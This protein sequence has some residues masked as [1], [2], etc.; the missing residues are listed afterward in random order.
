MT[1]LRYNIIVVTM[2]PD[3][4][5]LSGA[6]WPVLPA[7]IHD[8]ALSEVQTDLTTNGWRRRLFNGLVR[9]CSDLAHAGCGS[10]Y[11]DGSFVTE[12]PWPGDYD[13]CWHPMGVDRTLMN[14]VFFDFSNGR[15]AQKAQYGGEFFPSTTK[16]DAH[17]RTFVE[18]FQMEKFTGLEKGILLIDLTNDPML[19]PKVTP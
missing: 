7:G 5:D 8:A 3:F 11:L 1:I 9:A 17:G 13:A 4:I 18:F 12:N 6:P 10:L 14:P 16:A 2:I 19:K 15:A